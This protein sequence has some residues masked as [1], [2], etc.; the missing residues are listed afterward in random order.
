MLYD[1]Y[2]NGY[3]YEDLMWHEAMQRIFIECAEGIRALVVRQS[4]QITVLI[5]NHD[6]EGVLGGK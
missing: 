5:I 4:D 2:V 6:D 1:A 3:L